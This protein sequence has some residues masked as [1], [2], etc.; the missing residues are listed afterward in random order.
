[1][2]KA[3]MSS[4]TELATYPKDMTL[5]ANANLGDLGACRRQ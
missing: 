1:M 3:F 2:R 5:D 4:Q